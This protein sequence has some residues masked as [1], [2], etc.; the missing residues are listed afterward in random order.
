MLRREIRIGERFF[1][2][3]FNLFGGFFQFQVLDP[4]L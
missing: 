2:A 3:V 4:I 1:N